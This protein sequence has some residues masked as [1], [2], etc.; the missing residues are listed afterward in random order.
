[1]HDED[2]TTLNDGDCIKPGLKQMMQKNKR[3]VRCPAQL[4]ELRNHMQK[5][6]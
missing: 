6:E 4:E 2:Q 3:S 1:M 5:W